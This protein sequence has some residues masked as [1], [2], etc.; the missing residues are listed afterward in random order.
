[1]D[2]TTGSNTIE[3]FRVALDLYE[4]GEKMMRQNLRR[5]Y[6]AARDEE[7]EQRLIEWLRHRPGAEHGDCDGRPIDWP[8]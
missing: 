2:K 1:M 6:P 4:V 7:I 8:R 3:R 5:R